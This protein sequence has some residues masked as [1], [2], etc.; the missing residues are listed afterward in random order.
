MLKQ[1]KLNGKANFETFEII[2]DKIILY[3]GNYKNYTFEDFLEYSL[4][5]DSYFFYSYD[6]IFKLIPEISKLKDYEFIS[7]GSSCIICKK[8]SNKNFIVTFSNSNYLIRPEI[9]KPLDS[10]DLYEKIK[11]IYTEFAPNIS[12]K[13][14]IANVALTNFRRNFMK[15]VSLNKIPLY[16]ENFIRRISTMGRR[17]IFKDKSELGRIVYHYDFNSM[18]ASVMIEDMPNGEIIYTK[19]IIEDKIGFY[20]CEVDVPVDIKIPLLKNKFQFPTGKFTG[21]YDGAELI[22]AIK[23]GVKINVLEGYYFNDKINIFK[24]Y[25][26]YYFEKK[27][28][29]NEEIILNRNVKDEV[30]RNKS[31]KELKLKYELSK[32]M[33][34]CL[35]GK[36]S[37]SRQTKITNYKKLKQ[38]KYNSHVENIISN[39]N[40]IIPSIAVHISSLARI[41]LYKLML[42]HKDDLLYVNVDSIDTYKKI[43]NGIGN[44]LGELKL[45]RCYKNIVFYKDNEYEYDPCDEY[46]NIIGDRIKKKKKY[47]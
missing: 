12:C 20:K 9:Y 10:K 13:T 23:R 24:D 26:N 16:I 17:E 40:Y 45:S 46:G 18:Y 35:Y 19:N 33:L 31:Y 27:K 37:E 2:K 8:I 7:K 1:L 11:L 32:L 25:V 6:D 43:I 39:S 38:N 44:K 36:F 22:E 41:K 29:F 5:K 42:E 21:I 28:Q 34:I 30:L 47:I 4:N 15:D 14:T 3:D